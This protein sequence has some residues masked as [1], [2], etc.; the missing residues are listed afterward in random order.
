MKTTGRS[1]A[2]K[3]TIS[4]KKPVQ[5]YTDQG[6]KLI[7]NYEC[8]LDSKPKVVPFKS[9]VS[10]EH[11]FVSVFRPKPQYCMIPSHETKDLSVAYKKLGHK[12]E[13]GSAVSFNK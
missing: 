10:R 11:H 5:K 2:S 8:L 13:A 6:S 9:E 7:L 12:K 1:E 4:R 3:L